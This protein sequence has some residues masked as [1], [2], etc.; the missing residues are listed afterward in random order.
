MGWGKGLLYIFFLNLTVIKKAAL[1]Y[2]VSEWAGEWG[3]CTFFLNNHHSL[4][5]RTVLAQSLSGL[6]N[7]VVVHSF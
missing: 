2:T 3:C 4:I 5:K 1:S 6:E 7:G